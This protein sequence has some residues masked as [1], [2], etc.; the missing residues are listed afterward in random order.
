MAERKRDRAAAAED[1]HGV[2]ALQPVSAQDGAG[3][4]HRGAGQVRGASRRGRARGASSCSN[5]RARRQGRLSRAALRRP[6][7]ARGDRARAGHAAEADAVR[8]ADSRARPGAGRRGARRDA[9]WPRRHDHD[10]GDARDGLR[11]RG[12]RPVVFMTRARSS[13]RAAP[14]TSGRAAQERT[15]AFLSAVI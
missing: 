9:D 4:H 12:R 15:K 5:G 14:R 2:P 13:S 6:A 7:A 1:R 8:R 10:G 3:K 11:A